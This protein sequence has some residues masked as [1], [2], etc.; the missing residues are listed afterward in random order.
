MILYN[1]RSACLLSVS[2]FT[3]MPRYFTPRFTESRHQIRENTL[4]MLDAQFLRKTKTNKK[5]TPQYNNKETEIFNK[6][7]W[8]YIPIHSPNGRD[9]TFT[10]HSD[11]PLITEFSLSSG[12]T[13]SW[14][15]FPPLTL[16]SQEAWCVRAEVNLHTPNVDKRDYICQNE[17]KRNRSGE[18]WPGKKEYALV[19]YIALQAVPCNSQLEGAWTCRVRQMLS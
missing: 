8:D 11:T 10:T 4:A 5:H 15:L 2:A 17:W 12:K 19:V 13:L 7:H 6:Q 18:I 9:Y 16:H 1:R 14:K 3:S